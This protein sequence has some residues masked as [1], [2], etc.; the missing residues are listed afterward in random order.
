M[1]AVYKDRKKLEFLELKQNN[2]AVADYKVQFIRLSKYTPEEVITDE[3]KR[4]KFKRGLNLKIRERI[5]VKPP[6]YK[7]LLEAALR[8]E[9][10]ILEKSILDTNKKRMTSAFTTPTGERDDLSFKTIGTQ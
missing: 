6:T 3:L 4:N 5:A 9:E 2:L 10:T 8:A 1:P 7:D